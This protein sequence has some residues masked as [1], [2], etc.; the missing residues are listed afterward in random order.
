MGHAIRVALR[1]VV[2]SGADQ[3]LGIVAA[4]ASGTEV[5]LRTKSGGEELCARPK[6][7]KMVPQGV[8]GFWKVRARRRRLVMS[9]PRLRVGSLLPLPLVPF[10]GLVVLAPRS[11]RF[12]SC[13]PNPSV[14]A[15]HGGIGFAFPS[16]LRSIRA[17][18]SLG[19]PPRS[20]SGGASAMGAGRNPIMGE[21]EGLT[22]SYSHFF[23]TP[24]PATSTNRNG[25][26]H[27]PKRPTPV[28]P[29]KD[30]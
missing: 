29:K 6:T 15:G 17:S 3:T 21:Y 23:P 16:A 11:S 9:I 13:S 2:V 5:G 28:G 20:T 18:T 4:E 25:I 27:L 7:G 12:Q 14:A 26:S 24:N 30:D 8:A 19:P 22:P 10:C 1:A